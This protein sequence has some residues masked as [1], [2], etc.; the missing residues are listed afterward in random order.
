MPYQELVEFN[1]DEKKDIE[2]YIKERDVEYP[3]LRQVIGKPLF[4]INGLYD[5]VI[6]L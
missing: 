1:K 6:M 5:D 4:Y 2:A 3:N